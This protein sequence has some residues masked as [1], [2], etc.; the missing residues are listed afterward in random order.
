M[1]VQGI[2]L[3]ASGL[4]GDRERRSARGFAVSPQSCASLDAMGRTE[5]RPRERHARTSN[6]LAHALS[7][8]FRLAA[9]PAS[10]FLSHLSDLF[11]RPAPAGSSGPAARPRP[12]RPA[13]AAA[14]AV[15]AVAA[16]VA[17]MAALATPVSAQEPEL[18][19]NF[20]QAEEEPFES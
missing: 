16:L 1:T 6:G 7:L 11:G 19:S 9:E 15:R 2:V 18:V 14:S 13:L 8:P 4:A 12:F 17:V 10:S 5:T 3:T 20:D